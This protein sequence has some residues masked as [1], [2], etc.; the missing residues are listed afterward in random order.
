MSDKAG[1]TGRIRRSLSRTA[2]KALGAHAAPHSRAWEM[3]FITEVDRAHVIMLVESSLLD[4]PRAARLLATI[5]SLAGN[6]FAALNGRDAPRG[7]YLL[8]ENH[9]IDL[10]G[11]EVGG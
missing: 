5:D 8:Y 3:V 7:L 10:L 1:D 11:E 2:F 4:R 6:G 9:L